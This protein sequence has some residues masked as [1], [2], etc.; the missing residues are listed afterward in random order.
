MT[1]RLLTVLTVLMLAA[2]ACSSDDA[3]V[4][5]TTTTGADTTTTGAGTGTTAPGD[6][7]TPD[8]LY[9]DIGAGSAE[10][11]NLTVTLDEAAAATAKIGPDGGEVTATSGSGVTFTLV[12]PPEAVLSP[13]AITMTPVATATGAAVGDAPLAMVH[14]APEGF[15][16]LAPATLTITGADI[17]N[18]IGLGASGTGEDAHLLTALDGGTGSVTVSL[19]H[20]SAVAIGAQEQLQDLVRDYRPSGAEQLARTVG[21]LN[22]TD[23]ATAF[24]ALEVWARALRLGMENAFSTAD[25]EARTAELLSLIQ[26]VD[27]R[28]AMALKDGSDAGDQVLRTV[29]GLIDLWFGKVNAEVN[30]LAGKCGAGP[31]AAFWIYRWVSI[32]S[33]VTTLLAIDRQDLLAAW[34]EAARECLVFEVRWDTQVTLVDS[35]ASTTARGTTTV[36]ADESQAAT[37]YQVIY[38]PLV[39]GEDPWTMTELSL[40]DC[41]P[42]YQPGVAWAAVQP[43]I[44]LENPGNVQT[45]E[46]TG[47][48]VALY[49][50]TNPEVQCQEQIDVGAEVR[51]GTWFYTGPISLINS[52]RGS[53]SGWIFRVE[54]TSQTGT[55]GSTTVTESRTESGTTGTVKQTVTVKYAGG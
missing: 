47:L 39:A 7:G 38:L 41:S 30:R 6:D 54:A 37:S 40:E 32:G 52:V 8:D 23:H 55:M 2:T 11:S 29:Q 53:E 4:D 17:E 45:A 20:F 22:G 48:G 25:L 51:W 16:F 31:S 27:E 12:V 3:A 33:A 19:M 28:L 43:E 49:P 46:I 14:L 9:G 42:V 26:A 15:T 24:A 10:P 13:T 36:L 35:E 5:T 50:K 34:E 44:V 1:M 18:P 21:A